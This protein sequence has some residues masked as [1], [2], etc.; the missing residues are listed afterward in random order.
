MLNW[1]LI[2]AAVIGTILVFD[3][4]WLGL[5]A[6]KFYANQLGTLMIKKVKA[7]PALAFYLLFAVGLVILAV[8]PNDAANT[9]SH[10]AFLGAVVGFIAY[11]TY[12]MTNYAT[13]RDWPIK[14]TAVDWP[15]GTALSA[16][17]AAMGAYVNHLIT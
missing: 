4:F 11:G 6:R 14:M 7:L 15:V 9:I 10:S 12:N 8:R 2:Y 5:I 3:V 1:L 16:L 13:L 17:A